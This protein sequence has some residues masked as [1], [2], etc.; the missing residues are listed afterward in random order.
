MADA[1]DPTSGM[2]A[3]PST[4]PALELQRRLLAA[5]ASNE[6]VP[7]GILH[8]CAAFSSR[9]RE[10]TGAADSP[11]CSQGEWDHI[12]HE[13]V[14]SRHHGRDLDS[15]DAVSARAAKY[16]ARGL[17]PILVAD[18]NFEI[19]RPR[20]W[21]A[22]QRHLTAQ[23]APEAFPLAEFPVDEIVESR[24]AFFATTHVETNYGL[25]TTLPRVHRGLAVSFIL[26]RDGYFSNYSS[27]LA[28]V[29]V[30]FGRGD[31]YQAMQWDEPLTIEYAEPGIKIIHLRSSTASGVQYAHFTLE[32]VIDTTPPVDASWKLK[33]YQPYQG[34]TALGHAWVFYGSINGVKKTTLT[35][36]VIIAE[37]FPGN[38]KLP[39]L[40]ERLN[41]QGLATTMLAEGRDLVILGFEDGTLPIQANAYVTVS[42]IQ[43]AIA[44]RVGNQ[45]LQVGGASM[46][47]LV[48]RYALTFMEK[49][50]LPHQTVRFFTIDSPHGGATIAPAAQ[51]FVQYAEKYQH[52]PFAGQ[53]ASPAAQQMLL[54]WI[55][56][57]DS[58]KS[59]MGLGASPLRGQ[60]ISDLQSIGWMPRQPVSAA[61]ADGVGTGAQN[62]STPGAMA[63]SFTATACIW[64][65]THVFPLGGNQVTFARMEI[66]KVDS[67]IWTFYSTNGNGLDSIPGGLTPVFRLLYNEF[68]N[69]KSIWFSDACF[70]PT[71]SACAVAYGYF[72]AIPPSGPSDFN[73]YKYSSTANLYHVD[74]S[75]ELAN[76]VA[77]FI[78][79]K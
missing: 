29:E 31:G 62:G 58:W 67:N 52:T 55:P 51:A 56:P 39:D 68:P 6:N 2:E 43:Q 70:I 71:V 38:Y 11:V 19:V 42:C 3:K 46:G 8:R 17:T 36:P 14:F 41:Q 13:L 20:F 9:I 16:V 61:I 18:F 79:G 44:Q 23:L 26:P 60:F 66:S 24:R 45:P 76:Y 21:V 35:E 34:N 1:N 73:R 77:D 53:L 37:G 25:L 12:Y 4:S 48:T 15:L 10:F 54:L 30:D 59:G 63:T 22:V 32:L 40:W 33:A 78:R 7:S 72:Q 75:P 69:S 50:D 28:G 47:G 5:L 74:L 64:D 65:E 27:E 57:Y 49:N